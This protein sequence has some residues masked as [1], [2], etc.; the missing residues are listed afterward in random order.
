MKVPIVD[1]K[2]ASTKRTKI[3]KSV[4]QILSLLGTKPNILFVDFIAVENITFT[5]S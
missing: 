2:N 1:L 4:I 3:E 5:S